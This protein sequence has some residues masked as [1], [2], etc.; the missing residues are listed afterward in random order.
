MKKILSVILA[1]MMLFGAMSVSASA[2]NGYA[3]DET[4]GLL[5]GYRVNNGFDPDTQLLI[6]LDFNGCKSFD[7]VYNC[8]D[9]KSGETYT[10]PV[11]TT[12]TV[13]VV[14]S[15]NN[16]F[17]LPLITPPAD[18]TTNGW[19][20]S[21]LEQSFVAGIN[22]AVHL[23]QGMEESVLYFR[24]STYPSAP[25]EDTM[26]TILG[27]LTKVFGAIIGI[28]FYG[29]STEAGVALMDKVL[30]GLDL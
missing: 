3:Y 27:V 15:I 14:A 10:S 19:Y 6:V 30:G 8:I 18:Y 21:T 4:T 13:V 22:G 7:P 16:D 9:S 28:L 1:V 11:E 25:E 12:G 26:A 5:G 29:G 23:T 17:I 20:C 24:A 2:A